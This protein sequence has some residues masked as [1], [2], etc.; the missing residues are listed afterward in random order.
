MPPWPS[1]LSASS[2]GAASNSLP[3]FSSTAGIVPWQKTTRSS[4]AQAEAIVLVEKGD[5]LVVRRGARHQEQ[6]NRH[7]VATAD[8]DQLL[9]QN[10]K[11]RTRR[12]PARSGTS[13]S[14]DRSR[15]ASLARRRRASR[16]R[17]RPAARRLRGG[18]AAS[19]ENAI[20]D[21]IRAAPTAA[22]WPGP[23]RRPSR[24][25]SIRRDAADRAAS[26]STSRSCASRR[27]R[28]VGRQRVAVRQQDVAGCATFE[29]LAEVVHEYHR[30]ARSRSERR[31]R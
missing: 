28:S 15:A 11:Q 26:K 17:C 1:G 30:L 3:V 25:A 21:A 31:V 20:V 4:F 22:T 5:R 2:P 7:A 24:R 8:G 12:R 23:R 27:S 16:R 6:R 10:L 13:P 14:D 19:T 9:E 29:Q 18:C